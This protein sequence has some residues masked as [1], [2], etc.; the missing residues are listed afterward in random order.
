MGEAE[1]TEQA[2]EA[3]E[4]EEEEEEEEEAV[5]ILT[6]ESLLTPHSSPVPTPP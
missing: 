4:E 2:E 3:A 5:D 6:H 1:A